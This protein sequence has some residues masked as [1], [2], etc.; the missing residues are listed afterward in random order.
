MEKKMKSL[1]NQLASAVDEKN[2][3]AKSKLAEQQ[4]PTGKNEKKKKSTGCCGGS[5]CTIM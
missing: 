1:E 2:K 5:D 3:I 4:I